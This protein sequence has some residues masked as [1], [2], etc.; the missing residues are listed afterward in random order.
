MRRWRPF[1]EAIHLTAA[2]V[3]TGAIL[4]AGVTAAILFPAVKKMD[5]QLP[6]YSAYT[7]EHWRIVGG[8]I[9]EPMFLAVDLVQ[10]VC[11]LLTF[12][13]LTAIAFSRDESTRRI[14][15]A[16]RSLALLV[17]FVTFCWRFFVV[18][19]PL[20]ET[21]QAYWKAAQAGNN[22]QA[23]VYQAAFDAGHGT[24]STLMQITLA[25]MLVATFAGIWN[26]VAGASAARAAAAGGNPT[27]RLEEPRLAKGL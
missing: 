6:A 1:L 25:A 13:T 26:A 21:L 27:K 9:G 19:P 14:S 10:F 4:M 3:C 16:V 24:S 20:N 11:L 18:T 7:G 8:H 17:A 5:P 15:F 22:D 2:G 23:G 12:G